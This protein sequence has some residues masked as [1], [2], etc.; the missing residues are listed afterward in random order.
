MSFRSRGRAA[1]LAAGLV[2]AWAVAGGPTRAQDPKGE[3]PATPAPA[4]APAAKKTY[5]P[6][7]RVPP[8]FG[9][10]GLSQEQREEIYKLRG[11]YLTQIADL[12]KQLAATRA[13][14]L[15]DC[16]KLLSD[17]Q[18]QMLETRRKAAAEKRKKAAPA[19]AT[20]APA[21]K[22]AG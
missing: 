19:S 15:A 8:Y 9:Q 14:M 17:T 5:D 1:A 3:K 2:V 6:A 11:K 21:P 20:T 18:K 22:P 16:E 10:I 7:R 13:S 4:Q 12:E